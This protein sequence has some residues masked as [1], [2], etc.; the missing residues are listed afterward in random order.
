MDAGMNSWLK[1][2]IENSDAGQ[3]PNNPDAQRNL[4]E[5][6]AETLARL[7][8]GPS[9]ADLMK[10]AMVVIRN[11]E[12]T[13]DNKVIA[14]DNFEQLVENIDNANNLETLG[15]WTPLV[16]QLHSIEADMRRM[17]AWCIGTAVQNN[18]AV[19]AVPKLAGLALRDRDPAVRKKAVY[20]LSSAVRNY[21]PG[22]DELVKHLPT[23]VVGSDKVAADDMDTI[24]DI[25]TKLRRRPRTESFSSE[26]K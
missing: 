25:M 18:V 3:D 5:L 2:S 16:D 12:A 6:D 14:F 21:Q 7:M 8:G 23:E 22:M 1:W 13:I 20:A 17:S 11:P 4:G 10:E 19:G 9:D 15:L 24:D 26:H